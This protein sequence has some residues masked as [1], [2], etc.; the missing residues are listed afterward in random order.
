MAGRYELHPLCALFPR[1]AGGEFDAL[2]RF[3]GM[4]RDRTCIADFQRSDSHDGHWNFKISDARIGQQITSRRP[5]AGDGVSLLLDECGGKENWLLTPEP[6][7]EADQVSAGRIYLIRSGK[8]GHVKIGWTASSVESRL[9]ELQCGNP[10]K[11]IVCRVIENMSR[12]DEASMHK[13]FAA[14]RIHGEWFC[15][16][17]LQESEVVA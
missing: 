13:R 3:S 7:A 14:L 11:L 4:R 12:R 8:R 10:E 16:R 1:L 17:V 5:I 2:W 6:R 9:A 15:A